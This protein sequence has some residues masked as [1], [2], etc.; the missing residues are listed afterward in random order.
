MT[1]RQLADEL[2]AL[3]TKITAAHGLEGQMFIH[4][5]DCNMDESEFWFWFRVSKLATT[6]QTRSPLMKKSMK[7]LRECFKAAHK[8]SPNH[9]VLM[10]RVSSP[11]MQVNGRWNGRMFVGY[12][13]PEW[14]FK[15]C[16]YDN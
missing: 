6:Y 11:K 8:H 3:F 4:W 14:I 1:R 2:V 5:D 16:I 7:V 15:I 9:T 13:N 12:P 10:F